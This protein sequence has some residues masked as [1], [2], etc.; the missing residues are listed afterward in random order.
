MT[1]DGFY[2]FELVV[3]AVNRGKRLFIKNT[4]AC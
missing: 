4:G 2:G 3:V 1:G